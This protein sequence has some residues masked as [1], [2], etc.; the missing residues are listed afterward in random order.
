MNYK[1]NSELNSKTYRY[2]NTYSAL[3]P[4]TCKIRICLTIVLFPDSP[5][6][7]ERENLLLIKDSLHYNVYD[8]RKWELLHLWVILNQQKSAFTALCLVVQI[9]QP[10]LTVLQ[11]MRLSLNVYVYLAVFGKKLM[12]GNAQDDTKRFIHRQILTR[13]SPSSDQEKQRKKPPNL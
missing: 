3:N 9:S 5:A 12:S 11:R 4:L 10:V 13:N 7:T 1:Q 8:L 2:M 6:P